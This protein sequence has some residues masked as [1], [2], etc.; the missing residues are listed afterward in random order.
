MAQKEM[1][2]EI[3]INGEKRDVDQDLLTVFGLLEIEKVESPEMVSVQL[4]GNVIDQSRYQTTPLATGDEID[5]L[6]F[7]G[8]GAFR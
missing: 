1:S 4:N 8:G 5:F 2:M 3:T 7:M 6:Y